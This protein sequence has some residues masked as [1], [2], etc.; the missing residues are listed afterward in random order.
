VDF[1]LELIKNIGKYDI[2]LASKSPRRIELLKMIGMKFKVHPS[3]VEEIYRDN[4]KP[5]EYVIK[6]AQEK[7]K[8]IAGRYTSSLIISADTIVVLNNEV[9]EKPHD[10]DQAFKILK[11][12]SGRTHEVITG[13][14][15]SLNSFT[16][17]V[18]DYEITKVIF[19]DVSDEE[20]ES[21]CSSGEPFDKAG[22]YGAQGIGSMIIEKVDGCFFNVVGLPLTKFYITLRQFLSNV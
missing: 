14:G 3:N 4:L 16:K 8:S 22:G 2:V 17:S 1:M 18:F 13:F 12:L 9:L 19:R 20:I 7:N 10:K 21:Y 15:I 11:K 6:N 5:V